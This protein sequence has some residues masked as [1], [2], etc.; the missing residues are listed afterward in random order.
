MAS[1]A[2]TQRTQSFQEKE[3]LVFFATLATLRETFLSF[4]LEKEESHER[5]K[6]GVFYICR[7]CQHGDLAY[8]IRQGIVDILC[9]RG[10]HALCRDN[11]HLSELDLLEEMRVKM[12]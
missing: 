4:W 6:D 8:G 5:S 1:H 12:I 3:F 9:P 7:G 11:G 10:L 2:E